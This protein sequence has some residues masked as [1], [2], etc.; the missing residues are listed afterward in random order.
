MVQEEGVGALP[1][2]YLEDPPTRRRT[3][4]ENET[5]QEEGEKEV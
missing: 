3:T 4:L 5:V 2:H 1:H